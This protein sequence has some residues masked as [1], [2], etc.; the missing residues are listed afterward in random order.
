MSCVL[1]AAVAWPL[2]WMGAVC[3]LPELPTDD[4]VARGMIRWNALAIPCLGVMAVLL[5]LVTLA[6][7]I[8]EFLA[9]TQPRRWTIVV[10]PLLASGAVWAAVIA[11]AIGMGSMG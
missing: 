10:V 6:G 4:V 8:V 3:V 2:C 5:S 9:S 11:F 1:T 7:A